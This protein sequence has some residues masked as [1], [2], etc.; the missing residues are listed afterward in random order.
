MSTFHKIRS[1]RATKIAVKIWAVTAVPKWGFIGFVA[2]K[3]AGFL[4]PLLV[5]L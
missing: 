3:K 5:L 1:H 4:T 2:A